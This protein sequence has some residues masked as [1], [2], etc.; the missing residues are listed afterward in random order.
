MATKK[1]PPEWKMR[2]SFDLDEVLFVSPVDHKTEPPLRF[3]FNLI[4]RERLRLGTPLLISELQKRGYE[5]WI[6]TSSYRSQGYIRSLFKHYGVKLDGIINAQ[7]HLAEVQRDRTESLP[8]KLPSHYGISLHVDDEI[9]VVNYGKAYGFNVYQLD[10]Q[11]DDWAEK[12][13]ARAA[14]ISRK[15]KIFA[16]MQEVLNSEAT[17]RPAES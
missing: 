16:H 14:E 12:I 15:E 5:V 6:Y 11:D 2:V 9:V 3:P 13:L 7:R 1:K 17:S 4:F 10:A 8:Q